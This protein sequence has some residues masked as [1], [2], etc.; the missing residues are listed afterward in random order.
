MKI[1]ESAC[2]Y[3][4]HTPIIYSAKKKKNLDIQ[5]T[6]SMFRCFILFFTVLNI[7]CG[8]VSIDVDHVE[9]C[10][11]RL[12]MNYRFLFIFFKF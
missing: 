7:K 8:R 12:K 10:P 9:W 11:L 2:F 1:Q 6:I 4:Q 3:P 5:A